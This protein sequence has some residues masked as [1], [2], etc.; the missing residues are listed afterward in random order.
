MSSILTL[1][2]IELLQDVREMACHLSSRLSKRSGDE[3]WLPT[4]GLLVG[5]LDDLLDTA[6]KLP[7]ESLSNG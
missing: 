1:D 3:G 5:H 2:E 4:I 6:A 7:R